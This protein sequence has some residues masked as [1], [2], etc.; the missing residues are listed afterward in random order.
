MNSHGYVWTCVLCEEVQFAD[1]RLI[2]PIGIKG[3]GIGI[4]LKD[5]HC[6][7][8]FLSHLITNKTNVLKDL[9]D[10][11]WLCHGDGNRAI[12]CNGVIN[13]NAKEAL[14]VAFIFQQ[15]FG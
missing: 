1:D 12:R 5:V 13:L 8:A 2:V 4:Q 15:E 6:W 11:T 7:C 3:S 9:I 10:Q 14:N